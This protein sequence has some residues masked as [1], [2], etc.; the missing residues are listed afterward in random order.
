MDDEPPAPTPSPPEPDLRAAPT[1]PSPKAAGR[2]RLAHRQAAEC[3]SAL[4]HVDVTELRRQVHGRPRTTGRSRREDPAWPGSR[5]RRRGGSAA[6]SPLTATRTLDITVDGQKVKELP[7]RLEL[8]PELRGLTAALQTGPIIE[9]AL[10][11][12]L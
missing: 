12:G 2:T 1:R 7:V 6:L 11:R 10:A 8:E 3:L 5:R 9:T 4:L